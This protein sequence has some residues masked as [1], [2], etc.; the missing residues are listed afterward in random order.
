[1]PGQEIENSVNTEVKNSENPMEQNLN[2]VKKEVD[3]LK[4]ADRNINVVEGLSGLLT[5]E[6][7]DY[8]KTQ[9]DVLNSLFESCKDYKN[10][11]PDVKDTWFDN[12]Y[13]FL[14]GARKECA[15]I[16]A[17]NIN[18]TLRWE[19]WRNLEGEELN[20]EKQ[21]IAEELNGYVEMR[22][23]LPA[24][25]QELLILTKA[26]LG[27]ESQIIDK[28]GKQ[29]P[30]SDE[31]V[32]LEQKLVSLWAMNETADPGKNNGVDWKFWN[33][34]Y[35][36]LMSQIDK[37][38]KES[39]EIKDIE[40][41]K[42]KLRW[43]IGQTKREKNKEKYGTD[44]VDGINYSYDSYEEFS[45]N[46]KSDAMQQIN[47]EIIE[48]WDSLSLEGKK[49]F[50]LLSSA[51]KHVSDEKDTST[52][53][54]ELEKELNRMWLMPKEWTNGENN[55][56]DWKFGHHTWN[57]VVAYFEKDEENVVK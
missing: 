7:G 12:L 9:P 18:V 8:L 35:D 44:T 46:W 45:K 29:E 2:K 1:M 15:E 53:V 16:W 5:S 55:G 4:D 49:V 48:S 41:I 22:D 42:V 54:L 40:E 23:V 21:K 50:L 26:A 30:Y 20:N 56:V 33:Q 37:S 47:T 52:E 28:N 34:T 13:M 32:A 24:E 38:L 3:E 19:R 6:F 17:N 25:T 39:V 51:L 36:A 10:K 31:V 27:A 57:A 43:N 11:N 14:N